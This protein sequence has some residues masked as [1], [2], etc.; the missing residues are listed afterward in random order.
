MAKA[1]RDG[2]EWRN[3][4]DIK[5]DFEKLLLARAGGRL[6]IFTGLSESR[7]KKTAE[8]L[9]RMVREFNGSRAE[10]AWL[11]AAWEGSNDDWSFRYGPPVRIVLQA[12]PGRSV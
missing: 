2:G 4:G 8:R 11:L 7:S 3:E 5:D 10:D 6:M 12:H 9:A 1:Y